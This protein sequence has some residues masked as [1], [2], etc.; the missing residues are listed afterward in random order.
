MLNLENYRQL[1]AKLN[2]IS[3]RRGVAYSPS[4]PHV[5]FQ[6]TFRLFVRRSRASNL[7]ISRL[8][9]RHM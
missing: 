2:S 8:L 6:L 9:S 5:C 7:L 4:P 3:M 1:P